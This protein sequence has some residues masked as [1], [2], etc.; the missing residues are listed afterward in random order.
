MCKNNHQNSKNIFLRKM[1]LCQ[2]VCKWLTT[3]MYQIWRIYLS[4]K[5]LVW[6]TFGFKVDQSHSVAMKLKLDMSCHLLSIYT[7]FEIDISKHV[8]KSKENLYGRTDRNR[9]TSPCGI[10]RPFFK[11][12][13]ISNFE[14]HT[15][16]LISWVFSVKFPSGECHKISLIM[17]AILVQVMA[18]CRQVTSHYLNK[19]W[20]S[21]LT[22][23]VVTRPQWFKLNIISLV[24]KISWYICFPLH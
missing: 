21:S 7:K 19:C 14:T 23:Y 16:V 13:I 11:W 20:P 1:N 15:T 2:E 8:E 12:R 22:P 10:I 3:S 9:Q 6:S 4:A 5:I 18:W 17:I 24:C